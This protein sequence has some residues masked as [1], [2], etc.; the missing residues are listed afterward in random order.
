M[1]KWKR[2]IPEQFTAQELLAYRDFH[3]VPSLFYWAREARNSNAEI[4]YVIPY[5]PFKLKLIG[6]QLV[7]RLFI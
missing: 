5:I 3:Q 7:S 1:Q 2:D 6:N 4:D